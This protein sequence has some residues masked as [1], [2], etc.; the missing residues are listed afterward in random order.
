MGVETYQ[1]LKSLLKKKGYTTAVGDEGG[2]APNLSA[3]VEAVEIILSAI[4]LAGFHADRD[5]VI[6]LDPAAS[7]FFSDG[8]YFFRKS[9]KAKR[10]SSDMIDFYESWVKQYPI[11]SIEDGLAEDDWTGWQELTKRLGSRI[12]LVGDD[13]FVTNPAIIQ[14]GI[15]RQVA[16]AVLIKLNQIGTVTETRAAIET[17]RKAKYGLVISH[18]SGETTDDFIADFAVGTSCAQIKTGAPCRGER[19][20]KYNQLARI[21]RE[22]GSR[23]LYAG[24]TPFQSFDTK[25]GLPAKSA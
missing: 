11:L 23:A 14:Q 2:F 10:S 9:D 15:D 13:I 7:E 19:V 20:A 17:A 18:R 16:N 4:E 8:K 12:Q 24:K 21:E 22:L 3:N 5:I 6:A 1:A 25:V